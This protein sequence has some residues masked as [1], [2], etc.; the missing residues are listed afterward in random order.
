[1][2]RR[3][4]VA[5]GVVTLLTDFGLQDGYVAAMKGV[6]LTA[7]HDLRLVD[8]SHE[9]A[10]QNIASAAYL[11]ASS[12]RWFP[13]GSV[14]LAVVDPGVG[15]ERAALAV[16]ANRHFFVAPD[17]GLL[18]P[19]VERASAGDVRRIEI[20]DDAAPTFHGRDVFA[21]AAAR[22]AC[23]EAFES[24]GTPAPGLIRLDLG[25]NPI[26][27]RGR[28]GRVW[29]IDRFGNAIT[30]IRDTDLDSLGSDVEIEV[31]G[32][33]VESIAR[34]Y[35]DVE[36]GELVALIGSAGTLEIAIRDGDAA[37]ELGLKQGDPVTVVALLDAGADETTIHD[38]L[39][40]LPIEGYEIR[41]GKVLRSSLAGTRFEVVLDATEHAHR[42]LSD[43]VAILEAGSL[44]PRVLARAR[45]VFAALAQAEAE[46][47]GVTPDEVHFH[48]VGAI[49]AI[50]DVVATCLALESLDVTEVRTRP[51]AVGGGTVEAAHGTLPVPAPATARL[52]RGWP[53]DHGREDGELTTPT[54]AAIIAA[55][56]TPEPFTGSAIWDAVGHGAGSRDPHGR[57]NLL[58]VFVGSMTNEETDAVW[59]VECHVDDQP[60]EQ[61]A[62]L[63][64]RLIE[65]GAR[66]A[67]TDAITGKKGR[68][69]I[70][71]TALADGDRLNE[72]ENAI[73]AETTTFGLRRFRVER[74]ILAR[75][76][77]TVETELG[78]VRM[79]VGSRDGET[80]RAKPEYEDCRRLADANGVTVEHVAQEALVAFRKS[81]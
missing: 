4:P 13:E 52:L 64:D 31:R 46:V 32:S 76:I 37:G 81:R 75:E 57:P 55:L 41:I 22:L 34:T 45:A 26:G 58:R 71:V 62:M 16:R 25:S 68:T 20:P 8:V 53:I 66:D 39:A 44:S 12:Y 60:P 54:G 69:A 51:I 80:I 28:R 63:P 49:D 11:L 10:A 29:H 48:E 43:V 70:R 59:Q 6:L 30:T 65:A 7:G 15:T 72:V 5:A 73:F 47:H 61:L 38:G 77:V 18:T 40:S 42:G 2:I 19:V 17:N 79:K 74:S 33:R 56:A 35:A 24:I 23:G 14:H 36:P 9:V 21:P 67:W 50:V 3:D 1:V 27:E 78:A